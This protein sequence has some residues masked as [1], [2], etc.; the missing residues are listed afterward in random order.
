MLDHLVRNVKPQKSLK[1]S[2]A[3]PNH[4]EADFIN[5]LIVTDI[6]PIDT[7]ANIDEFFDN[8]NSGKTANNDQ[9][10]SLFAFD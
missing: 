9:E 8:L 10:A 3:F 1:L 4:I 5:A 2:W 7:S 6:R